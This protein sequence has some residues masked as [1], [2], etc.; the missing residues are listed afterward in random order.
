M[1]KY[2]KYTFPDNPEIKRKAGS[3]WMRDVNNKWRKLRSWSAVDSEW[4]LSNLGKAYYKEH[5]SAWT[6]SIP[7]HYLIAKPGDR[8]VSYKGYFPVS[9]LTTSLRDRL[10]EMFTLGFGRGEDRARVIHR[11]KQDVLRTY[12]TFR[13]GYASWISPR[14]T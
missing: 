2:Y 1:P 12:Y 4:Q 13:V 14:Y 11:M 3:D 6:I 7:V 8:E 10:Q 9:Q 5:Q